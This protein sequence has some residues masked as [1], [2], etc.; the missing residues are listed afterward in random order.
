MVNKYQVGDLLRCER[1]G[2]VFEVVLAPCGQHTTID[3]LED[4]PAALVVDTTILFCVADV[5]DD[6]REAIA[7]R[8]RLW[9]LGL[10]NN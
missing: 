6:E 10:A 9:Q 2:G 3:K 4:P 8:H 7:L 1:C 5:T